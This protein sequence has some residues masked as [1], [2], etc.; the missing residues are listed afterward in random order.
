VRAK[1]E[2]AAPRFEERPL[3]VIEGPLQR[4]GDMG[5]HVDCGV[6]MSHDRW[7]KTSA[8]GSHGVVASDREGAVSGGWQQAE[9]GCKRG[10]AHREE[11]RGRMG[12]R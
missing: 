12:H 4:E 3:R 2:L 6:G 10:A 5:F 1:T 7:G 8:L 11:G 9:A